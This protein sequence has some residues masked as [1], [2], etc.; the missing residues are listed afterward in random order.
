MRFALA[1]AACA[2]VAGAQDPPPSAEEQARILDD[3]RVAAIHYTSSLPNFLCTEVVRRYLPRGQDWRL[4]DTLLIRLAFNDNREDYT[5]VAINGR[6]TR[7]DYRRLQ[8]AGSTGEFGSLL[9]RVY[10]PA[11][12]TEFQWQRRTELRGRRVHVFA[13]YIPLAYNRHQLT[14][15]PRS[16]A[17]S[18][19]VSVADRGSVFIDAE[20]R[21]TIRIQNSSEEIPSDFGIRSESTTLDYDFAEVAGVRYLLPLQAEVRMTTVRTPMLNR[22]QFAG[23]HRFAAGVNISF[24]MP[25]PIPEEKLRETRP[26]K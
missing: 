21:E 26:G 6:T 7:L 25:A 2:V 13:F 9:L 23:Y 1:L 19:Q 18:Q 16:A 4:R 22:V 20:T 8:G 11:L 5:L 17:P 12:H 14:Y 15:R 24:E 10:H 3:A